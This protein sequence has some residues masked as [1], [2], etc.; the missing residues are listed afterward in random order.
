MEKEIPMIV[1]EVCDLSNLKEG[2]VLVDFEKLKKYED[3]DEYPKML[4]EIEE[5]IE[6]HDKEN[7]GIRLKKAREKKKIER[8]E[9]LEK[10]TKDFNP[11]DP[12]NFKWE[13]G[14]R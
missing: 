8:E 3:K 11:Q 13:I 1:K 12:F 14:G 7:I 6:R 5:F 2:I 9:R 10:S 4:K